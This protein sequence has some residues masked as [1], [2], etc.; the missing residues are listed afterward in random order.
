MI[1][2]QSIAVA[3]GAVGLVG[4]ESDLF[5]FTLKHSLMLAGL[6]GVITML[7]AYVFTHMIPQ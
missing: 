5:R 4:R 6:V 7:Q 2:P 1:S 3:S